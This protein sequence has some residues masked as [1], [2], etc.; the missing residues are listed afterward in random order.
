MVVIFFLIFVRFFSALV[1]FSILRTFLK[2]SGIVALALVLSFFAL[3]FIDWGELSAAKLSHLEI[4]FLALREIWIGV[5][6]ALPLAL[7]LESF[8]L[9]GRMV[10]VSRGAQLAEQLFPGSVVRMSVCE[11]AF[12][13]AGFTVFFAGGWYQLFMVNIVDSFSVL[14]LGNLQQEV[15]FDIVQIIKTSGLAIQNGILLSL[16]VV[17]LCW[18]VDIFGTVAGRMFERLNITI[19]I[20]MVK[21]VLGLAVLVVMGENL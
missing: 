6:Q 8:A 11:N 14:Q 19:E 9:T 13:L 3:S 16:P 2:I 15:V 21:L 18:L 10:D 12:W 20:T 17:I 7:V 4:F 1:L 5:L